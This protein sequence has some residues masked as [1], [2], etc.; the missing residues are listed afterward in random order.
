MLQGY[1]TY[2]VEKKDSSVLHFYLDK[3]SQEAY[4]I[5]KLKDISLQFYIKDM[6]TN[7]TVDI[8]DILTVESVGAESYVQAVTKP[9]HVVLEQNGIKISAPTGTVS[10]PFNLFLENDSDEFLDLRI[11]E[12][13]VNGQLTGEDN[14]N[15]RFLPHCRSSCPIS[16]SSYLKNAN[17]KA[18]DVT[19]IKATISMIVRY[20]D[21]WYINPV[22][23]VL[24]EKE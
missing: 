7:E 1:S 14:T 8:S 15:C 17:I 6:D 19:S 3:E 9:D 18:S 10:S 2:S 23:V 11:E 4:H 12:V 20:V 21:T 5:D 24:Y 16:L 22:Q 13:Y